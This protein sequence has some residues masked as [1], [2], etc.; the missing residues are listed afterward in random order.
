MPSSPEASSASIELERYTEDDSQ[1]LRYINGSHSHRSQD[2][3]SGRPSYPLR[4]FYLRGLVAILVPTAVAAY[5]VAIWLAYI[6]PG[7]GEQGGPLTIGRPGGLLIF[8]SWFVIGTLGLGLAEYGLAGVEASML[9]EPGWAASNA[10][11]LM[12]HCEGSWSGPGGWLAVTRQLLLLWRRRDRPTQWPSNLWMLLA[13]LSALPYLALPLSGLCMEL[14]D[15]FVDSDGPAAAVMGRNHG[16][17]ESRI[18]DEMIKQATERWLSASVPSLPG[19]GVAYAPETAD[20]SEDDWSFLNTLPHALPVRHGVHEIFLAPQASAPIRGTAWGVVLRYNCSVV[21]RMADFS[22]L[23]HR[24]GKRENTTRVPGTT[25]TYIMGRNQSFGGQVF[26]LEA[27]MEL[28]SSS[29]EGLVQTWSWFQ[30]YYDPGDTNYTPPAFD[31]ATGTL[32]GDEVL[33]VALWQSLDPD[34][35]GRSPATTPF[36][37]D[38]HLE[39]TIPELGREITSLA[40]GTK[41]SLGYM[42]AIGARCTSNS[43]VGA[44]AIEGRSFTFRDFRPGTTAPPPAANGSDNTAAVRF[45]SAIP[46]IVLQETPFAIGGPEVPAEW[47]AGLFASSQQSAAL[48]PT[49]QSREWLAPSPLQPSSLIRSLLQAHA[50]YALQLEYDGRYGMPGGD[51]GYIDPNVTALPAGKVLSVGVMSPVFVAV[52]LVAWAVVSSALGCWYGF[53]RRW[54]QV[55]DGYSMFRFGADHGDF[56]RSQPDFGSAADFDECNSLRRIPGMVGNSAPSW[57]PGHI[58]LV[59]GTYAPKGALYA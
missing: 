35:Y 31:A 29:Y 32:E 59:D 47:L 20:R 41:K 18:D 34:T 54:S 24:T 9:M 11:Q 23:N 57:T 25:D 46:P 16:D 55:L 48:V 53:R 37:P 8:Y 15:G 50:S 39:S 7:G 4:R 56:I 45:S 42:P 22:I 28:G 14:G 52:L 21:T 38:M 30:R 36:T 19:Q 43:A 58:G 13:G 27:Y 5:F 12:M 2:A 6:N 26:N 10:M 17:F 44:A 49:S 51:N 33:E 40:P 1:P 3:I